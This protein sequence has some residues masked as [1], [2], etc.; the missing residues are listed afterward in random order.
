MKRS[1]SQAGLRDAFDLATP[2][3]LDTLDEH[4]RYDPYK[5]NMRTGHQ[6]ASSIK[7]MMRRASTSMKRRP[8]LEQDVEELE[9]VNTAQS[10]G[11]TNPLKRFT[12]LRHRRP[13]TSGPSGKEARYNPQ[14]PPIIHTPVTLQ[15]P[16]E[17]GSGSRARASAREAQAERNRLSGQSPSRD[18]KF[19]QSQLTK[20]TESAV[21][22]DSTTTFADELALTFDEST[23][24]CGTSR[25]FISTR[26]LSI[27]RPQP[28]PWF[29]RLSFRGHQMKLEHFLS[30]GFPNLTAHFT[31][32]AHYVYYV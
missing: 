10:T 24:R 11:K 1:A 17:F 8:S 15:P 9:K 26:N 5:K 21:W 7:S 29:S 18:S 12:S 22:V 6:M 13:G 31:A 20:D 23:N 3:A 25:V 14:P 4:G 19:E 30:T 2:S 32:H 27:W 16:A 28:H